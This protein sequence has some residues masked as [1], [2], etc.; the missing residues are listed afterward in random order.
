MRGFPQTPILYT[1]LQVLEIHKHEKNFE[2]SHNKESYK[3][4]VLARI[5]FNIMIRRIGGKWGKYFLFPT[6]E[7]G[8]K[9]QNGGLYL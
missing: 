4:E 8:V 3:V 2:V 1:K 6:Q 5:S 7:M 9:T